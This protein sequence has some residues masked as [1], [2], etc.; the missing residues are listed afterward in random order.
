MSN[1]IPNFDSL[2]P[3][4]CPLME[5]PAD[6]MCIGDLVQLLSYNTMVL[7]RNLLNRT[8]PAGVIRYFAG[9][10]GDV[11]AGNLICDG[12]S[13]STTTYPV[14]GKLLGDLYRKSD[15]E[16]CFYLPD[17]RGKLVVGADLENEIDGNGNWR[18]YKYSQTNNTPTQGTNDTA[19]GSFREYDIHDKTDN[20]ETSNSSNI[21]AV[22]LIP[23]ITTGEVC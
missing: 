14:L 4:E 8:A 13:Y 21:G 1:N 2:S 19:S 16:T 5:Q 22:M 20:P 15:T 3:L 7:E 10:S 12:S 11:P 18:Y 9:S 6:S 23:I 17:L